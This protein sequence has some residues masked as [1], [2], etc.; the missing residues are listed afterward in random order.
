MWSLKQC[1]PVSDI[2]AKHFA[3]PTSVLEVDDFTAF[4]GNHD[5]K[6]HVQD[7]EDSEQVCDESDGQ[8]VEVFEDSGTEDE[9]E[10]EEHLEDADDEECYDVDD[11]DS[12]SAVSEEEGVN[13]DDVESDIASATAVDE[14][15]CESQNSDETDFI[16]AQSLNCT[17]E[18]LRNVSV[19]PSM[20]HCINNTVTVLIGFV[21]SSVPPLD[22]IRVMVIVWRLRGNIIRTAL[23]W[24]V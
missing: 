19:N 21:F 4:T 2:V 14:E 3:T 9:E 7:S 10:R 20:Y 22:N 8:A 5:Y 11:G 12:A 1:T 23:C 15:I 16:V 24:I 18:E 13:V 6:D 17:R